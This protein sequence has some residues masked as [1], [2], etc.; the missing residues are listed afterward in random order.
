MGK[1]RSRTANGIAVKT[2]VVMMPIVDIHPCAT[3]AKK[4]DSR[5][6]ENV[7]ASIRQFGFM[8]PLVVSADGEIVIGHCRYE[9]SKSLGVEKVPVMVA[10]HLDERQ[11]RALRVLDNKLNESPWDAELLAVEVEG[12]NLEAMGIKVDFE[13]LQEELSE[14]AKLSTLEYDPIYYEPKNRPNVALKDCVDLE[15]FNAKVDAIEQMD[16][17]EEQKET[18]R[19]F[20]YRF[21]RIDFEAVANYYAFNASEEEKKAIE[22]LRLVLVDSGEVGGYVED[23]MLRV[24]D[25]TDSFTDEEA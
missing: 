24:M 3:N 5:Q 6:V 4:H 12:L 9:A 14:T 16:L 25:I 17:T 7:A 20:A 22:R 1:D 15:K 13:E 23:G 21:I 2:E 18:L 11:L 8:Q 19:L 10:D